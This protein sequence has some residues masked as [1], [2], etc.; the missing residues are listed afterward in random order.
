MGGGDGRRDRRGDGSGD[1]RG[2]EGTYLVLLPTREF[3]LGR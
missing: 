2:K 3:V 1:R